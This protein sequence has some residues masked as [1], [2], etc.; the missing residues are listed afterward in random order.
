MEIQ[1]MEHWD[2]DETTDS[3]F[4]SADSFEMEK[5]AN[6]SF[7]RGYDQTNYSNFW[8]KMMKILIIG[9][10]FCLS[11]IVDSEYLS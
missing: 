7:K 3:A 8:T 2:T 9:I 6:E 11:D 4:S 5:A 10:I 1:D